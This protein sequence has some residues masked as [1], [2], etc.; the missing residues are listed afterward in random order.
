MEHER[1]PTRHRRATTVEAFRAVPRD[2]KGKVGPFARDPGDVPCPMIHQT[3]Y[4]SRHTLPE[5]F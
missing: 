5:P 3:P 4:R 2:G 1:G